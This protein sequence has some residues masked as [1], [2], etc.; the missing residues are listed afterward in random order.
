MKINSPLLLKAEGYLK[1]E[2]KKSSYF[3][4]HPDQLTYRIEHS[5]RVTRIGI[6]IAQGEA[7]D[8][9][10]LALACILHDL[11]YSRGFKN[12]ED[13]LNHGRTSADLAYNYLI[14]EG[15]PKERA[16]KIAF[17]ISIHVD[18]KSHMQGSYNA[19]AYS[20][21]DADNI[22][23]F[24]V[25]RIHE[26]LSLNSFLTLNLEDKMSYVNKQL[27]DL[28]KFKAYS[29]ATK[30]ADLLWKNR[31]IFQEDFFIRLK[32]QLENSGALGN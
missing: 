28:R 8:V 3:I 4:D 1:D 19:F 31:L 7:L 26:N 18:N 6:K 20:V 32:D 10:D 23:R 22:D 27:N 15:L 11:S 25:Y 5:L 29:F 12:D 24:D 30:T 9:E 17:A 2:L 21:R 14:N 16:D 13:R